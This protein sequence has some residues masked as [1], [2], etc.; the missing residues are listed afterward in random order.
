MK[1]TFLHFLM[2]ITI[3]F[4]TNPKSFT[5]DRQKGTFLK[6]GKPFRYVS[7][8]VIYLYLNNYF[9]FHVR[10]SIFPFRPCVRIITSI[11]AEVSQ[12]VTNKDC[13]VCV[14]SKKYASWVTL[15]PLWDRYRRGE[16]EVRILDFKTTWS[17]FQKASQTATEPESVTSSCVRKHT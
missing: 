4:C 14:K 12:N 6:D 11:P 10:L 3:V 1:R 15:R 8:K 16:A 9:D 2:C 5:V 7:G 13:L 17:E